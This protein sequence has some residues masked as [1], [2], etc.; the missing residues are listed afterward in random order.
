MQ[1]TRR[2]KPN[3]TFGCSAK[4]LLAFGCRSRK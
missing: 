1:G 4:H 2:R 3:R